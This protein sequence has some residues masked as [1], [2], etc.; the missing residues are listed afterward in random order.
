MFNVR[1]RREKGEE[2][3]AGDYV[4]SWDEETVEKR[5]HKNTVVDKSE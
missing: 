1:G 3:G 4:D 2:G 5:C